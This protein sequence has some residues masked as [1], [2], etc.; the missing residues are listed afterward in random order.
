MISGAL[1]PSHLGRPGWASRERGPGGSGD[2]RMARRGLSGMARTLHALLVGIDKYPDPVPQLSGCR[3]DIDAFEDLLVHRGR[4]GDRDPPRILTLRDDQAVRAAVLAGFTEHLGRAGR[5]DVALFYSCGHGSQEP[6]PEALW[7]I[8]PDRR[9]E[10]IP[11]YDSRLPGRWDL[12]DK[13]R[14]LLIRDLAARADHVVVILDCCHSDSGTRGE[15]EPV[16]RAPRDFRARPI[17]SFLVD[18]DAS[19]RSDLPRP[20]RPD[21]SAADGIGREPETLIEAVRAEDLD[22]LLP[23]GSLRSSESWFLVV[24][25]DE[26]WSL[27]VNNSDVQGR[28]IIIDRPILAIEKASARDR[29]GS[30]RYAPGRASDVQGAWLTPIGISSTA[31]RTDG[32]PVT[33]RPAMPQ[34]SMLVTMSIGVPW[35]LLAIIVTIQHARAE[36]YR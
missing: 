12:A 29:S 20:F 1:R 21:Q 10:T 24:T 16:R 32:F 2:G 34:T 17:N 31:T 8:E 25:D 13:E 7:P 27:R 36:V 23:D 19:R 18:E 15:S 30:N 6:A 14:G 9:D 33:I 28:W 26:G 11:C 22:A 4:G 35:N 5:D 3:N